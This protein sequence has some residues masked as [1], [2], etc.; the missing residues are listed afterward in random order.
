MVSKIARNGRPPMTRRM[1]F[2]AVR[3]TTV[4]ERE[5]LSVKLVRK[6]VD[7]VRSGW[8]RRIAA[9]CV[10]VL[11]LPTASGA[12]AQDFR[13]ANHREPTQ[14]QN[15]TPDFAL[16][17]KI[18]YAGERNP[19]SVHLNI[20]DDGVIYSI[21]QTDSRFWTVFD[22]KKSQVVLLDKKTKTRCSVSMDALT[23]LAAQADAEVTDPK[24]RD[25]L[26][27]NA[28]V[29][30]LG[31]NQFELSYPGVS[32]KVQ[33]VVPPSPA[34]AVANAQLVDWAC[35]LNLA[36]PR[37]LPPF[38]RMRLNEELWKRSLIGT[39]TSLTIDRNGM[40][41]EPVMKAV[42]NIESSWS[43]GLD[44][45]SQRLV[46]QAA[47]YSVIYQQVSWKDFAD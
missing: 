14:S 44:D 37:G 21:P 15:S 25:R 28:Q 6:L 20:F 4:S 13:L 5:T 45:T 16:T 42:L 12:I 32:Y 11:L 2:S 3:R 8:M 34:M 22:L 29:K 46:D 23:R 33:G 41:G 40:D 24:R 26:G 35:R 1:S 19:N 27:M 38:G 7:V 9:T 17:T 18:Y 36:R 39:Q 47:S 10:A 31:G 43:Q 30:D